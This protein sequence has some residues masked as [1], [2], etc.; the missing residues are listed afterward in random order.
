MCR[1]WWRERHRY[2]ESQGQ[3]GHLT[4]GQGWDLEWW[5][6]LCACAPCNLLAR[7]K[8]SN[9]FLGCGLTPFSDCQVSQWSTTY[10]CTS[11][12]CFLVFVIIGIMSSTIPVT[13]TSLSEICLRVASSPIDNSSSRRWHCHLFLPSPA[14]AVLLFFC[15]FYF[16]GC[17]NVPYLTL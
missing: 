3:R 14:L 6:S 11:C 5:L 4:R 15:C 2:S 7:A 10:R 16:L 13:V 12:L 1:S 17:L 8:A 9:C